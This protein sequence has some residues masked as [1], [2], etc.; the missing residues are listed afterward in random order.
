MSYVAKPTERQL[1]WY[2]KELGVLIHYC[3]E[4]YEPSF[5]GYKTN[6]VRTVLAPEKINPTKLDP[7]QWVRAAAAVGAKYAILVANHC[8]GFSLWPTKVNDYCTR[9][10][11]WKDGQG[12]IVGEF[13][14]ACKKYG[15]EPGLYY[16][17]GCNGYYNID[18][19][20]PHDYHADYYREYVRCVEEQVKELW[21]WYGPL[22]EI[23][24]DGGCISAED[25]G[26]DLVP[27]LKKYQPD[28]VCFQGPK[29]YPHNLRWC[30]TEAG[31]APENCWA[32]TDDAEAWYD[33]TVSIEEAG[34]GNPDGKIFCPAE[35]DTPN[36]SQQAFG[37]GWAWR[38]GEEHLVRTPEELLECYIRSV[39]R[40]SNLLLGMSISTDGDFQD[41]EQFIAFGELLKERFGT[42][43]VTAENPDKAFDL[44]VPKEKIGRYLV[45]QEDITNG[46]RIRGY[47]VLVNGDEVYRG[48]C[49]GHKRILP[50]E[51]SGG[52]VVAVEITNA[53]DGWTWR[54]V[55]I[56]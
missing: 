21:T 49:I 44:T 27:M 3:M 28:A 11:A 55:A 12:D 39:G 1:D 5:R 51:L 9:S 4:I 19:G 26:P 43:V 35:T 24:F 56:Y 41:E 18:D 47:R 46:Q 10:L 33:G 52:D 7:A 37:G 22:F 42:P 2:E 13:I 34:I 30:G 17:P 54:N 16:S 14:E 32:T 20:K 45:L 31:L 38:A 48:Q 25:G 36:R 40:N 29:Y 23:W 15:L 53:V 6:A 8:T 50:L